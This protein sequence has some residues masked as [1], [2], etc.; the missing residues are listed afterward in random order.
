MSTITRFVGK[1]WTLEARDGRGYVTCAQSARTKAYG[2][3]V[4]QGSEF[5]VPRQVENRL[6]KI[7][8]DSCHEKR[9]VVI[10]ELK[11]LGEWRKDMK[12][13]GL[14]LLN[15]C[16]RIARDIASIDNEELRALAQHV[17]PFVT[18]SSVSNTSTIWYPQFRIL[19]I[20]GDGFPMARFGFTE[21]FSLVFCAHIGPWNENHKLTYGANPNAIPHIFPFADFKKHLIK[22]KI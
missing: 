17:D 1:R 22:I 16:A 11:R 2:D 14:G 7:M 19:T 6:F 10:E 9:V 21:D 20:C 3:P 12:T 4:Y 18:H 8:R 15:E 13:Y 5:T